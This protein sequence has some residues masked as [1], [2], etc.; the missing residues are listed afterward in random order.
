MNIKA[1]IEI[2][3]TLV[4][5]PCASA[6]ADGVQHKNTY[7][8]DW[9]NP[10]IIGIN[11]LPYHSTLQLPSREAE[12]P[13]I[14][15]LN[16]Q[17]YF[18]WSPNPE[19]R[20]VDFWRENF[21]VSEWDMIT[22]PGNWQMQNFGKPIYTNSKYPFLRNAPR[23]MKEP[24]ADWYSHDHRNPVGSYVTS[25]D[26]SREMLAQN[27]ILHFA[28]VKSAMYV[29][30]N[31]QRV[32]YS[33]NPMSPAEFDITR[34]LRKGQ[35]RL[36]VEVYRWSDGSYLEDV[37]MWRLS[38]IFRS[39]QLWVRPL[40]HI[41]DYYFR[42][43]LNSTFD[44]ADISIDIEI[45]NMGHRTA[46][47]LSAV[48]MLDG[49]EEKTHLKNLA[50]GDTTHAQVTFRLIRPR[51]WSAEKPNLYPVAIELRDKKGHVIEHF[52]NHLGVKK[53]EV[54][55]EVF[56]VNG[57]NIKLRGVNRHDHHPRMGRHVDAATC[58]L[59][60]RL[61]KQANINFLRTTVYPHEAIIYELADRYGLY[62]MDEAAN[63]SHGYGIGNKELGNDP[64]WRL[65]HVD[66]AT[67][68]VLRD[69]NHPCIILWSL[70]NEAGGGSN[71]RAMRDTVCALDPSI[72]PFYDS[73]R[74]VSAIYDDSYLYP[75]EMQ[76]VADRVTD[77]PFMMREYCHAMGNSMGNLQEYW[78]L[79]Y[80]DSSNCGAAIWDWADQG[81]AKPIDGSPL[82][83]SDSLTL[84]S[85]EFWA[86]GGDFGDKPNDGRFLIN[87]IVAPDRT[88]HPQYY[89]VQ[90]VYQPIHFQRD[91]D[92]TISIVNHDFFTESEEYDITYDTL[93]YGNE[94]FLN[95]SAHLRADM[96]WAKKG[97]AVAREQF[98]LTPYHYQEAL[99]EAP[100]SLKATTQ[101][102]TISTDCGS[103]TVDTTGALVSW[104]VND[105]E[106]LI[107][108]LEPYFWKPANDN[109]LAARYEQRLG[110]WRDAAAQRVVKN[111]KVS[112]ATLTIEA[113]LPIGADY[114]LTY[115]FAADGR[116]RV[117]ADYRPT[118]TDLPLMPKFGM[119]LR[120]PAD[121]REVRYYGRGPWENYP[122]RKRS[123]FIG[124]Y[125]MP[126]SDFMVDYVH[127]QDNGNRCDVRWLELASPTH[128]LR[129]DGGQPLCIRAWDYGEEDLN[130]LHP[131]ELRR[132]NFVNVNIDLNLHGVGGTDTWGKLTLPQYTVDA[133]KPMRYSF[134][135]SVK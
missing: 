63:E 58:E 45:C 134:I 74:S 46:K 123:A 64:T 42:T 8:V 32:G 15:S 121:F 112:G 108:P 23:V 87:G 40:T 57:K 52:D 50:A 17:W 43:N 16:G 65:A 135:I 3:T 80:A 79:I 100:A 35:N 105:R 11:K 76:R 86:Y 49:Q 116:I 36:C 132:G 9:E 77:R 39:V 99:E 93:H 88:P 91:Y 38:G 107:A 131:H 22:V 78:D 81:L 48:V 25:F 133:N 30:I 89:E 24:P 85:D 82:R 19:Q 59:D 98:V 12:C 119:R 21:D 61:M 27:V 18:H 33:Q 10:Q 67:S 122:D 106:M 113:T 44:Q 5:I 104:I 118:A 66:R 41:S 69:R 51:L 37:D 2:V 6:M 102:F 110:T 103:A 125:E 114:T 53:V 7:N 109:Q 62:V 14:I 84:Q 83:Y 73:D 29:W 92:G 124:E 1:I 96:P 101:G 26:V 115:T 128:R 55:G 129:I 90:H 97:F 94:T 120:L 68:L 72:P 75:D 20:P 28:G 117:E 126:L 47:E 70:G 71:A 31:G 13:E 130:V 34:Y 54:V 127:P 111:I 95:V 56:K 60:I 4:F